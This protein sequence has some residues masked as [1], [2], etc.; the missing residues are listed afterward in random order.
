MRSRDS[1]DSSDLP[2]LDEAA[3]A[4]L[5]GATSDTARTER[6]RAVQLFTGRFAD[7]DHWRSTTATERFG[8]AESLRAFAAFAAVFTGMA[9]DAEYVVASASKWGAHAA[10]LDPAAARD[11]ASQAESLGFCPLESSKMWSKLAQICVIAG[12]TPDTL[13]E[14]GYLQAR[15]EFHAAVS[16]K[17]GHAPKSLNAPLFGL[18]AVMFHRRQ[19]PKPNP[20]KSWAARSVPEIGWDDIHDKAPTMATTMQRYLGQLAVSLRPSSMACI[21]ITLRQFAGHVITN[22]SCTTIAG[23]GREHIEDYKTWLA[24][25]SGYRKNAAL[26]KTTPGMR[27]GH[28]GAFFTRI[29]E[30]DYPDVPARAPSIP[31]TARLRTSL[32]PVSSTTPKP[33]GSSSQ[34][35]T[36]RVNST[37]WPS[38]SSPAPG[39]AKANCRP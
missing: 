27:I 34:P 35:G 22:S 25:R 26:S 4:Y 31:R 37:A 8:D 20:R 28:L 11:F 15:A 16:T 18:D 23:I 3:L 17:C 21:E 30:W 38:R 32:C 6:A 1:I 29:I 2:G 19:A 39:C 33:P 24:G 10:R 13:D 36:C 12:A 7:L 5:N 9:V 14:A